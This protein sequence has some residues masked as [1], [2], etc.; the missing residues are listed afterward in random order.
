MKAADQAVVVG[1]PAV[2]HAGPFALLVV[3][4]KE[5]VPDEFHLVERVVDRH[6]LG[7]VFLGADDP[8]RR[9]VFVEVNGFVFMRV[10]RVV[11]E[12]VL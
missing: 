2:D 3:E 10:G 12:G 11:V 6:R 4:Q 7:R 8:P 1:V 9:V 5:V